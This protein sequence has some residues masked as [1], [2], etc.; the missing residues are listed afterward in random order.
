MILVFEIGSTTTLV[1]AFTDLDEEYPRFVGGGQAPTSVDEGDVTIGLRQAIANMEETTGVTGPYKLLLATSSAAGGLKMTVHGL[2]HDMTVRAA[3]E[4]ALGAGANI[5]LITSGRL[6]RTDLAK[7][8]AIEPNIILLA[9]GVDYGERETALFNAEQLLSLDLNVPVIYAG[10]VE[11]Q[12]EIRL[13]FEEAGKLERLFLVDNV[14]PRI[15]E[16][17]VLP[18]REVIQAVF[19]DH[20][21]HA[22]GM[23]KIRDMINSKIIPTPGSVMLATELIASELGDVMTVDV[24]GATTDI[25]SVTEGSEEIAKLQIAPEPKSKRTVEGDLGL[26]INRDNLLALIDRRELLERMGLTEELLEEVL[27]SYHP[28]PQ[29]QAERR[30]VHVLTEVAAVV[31]SHRHSGGLKDLFYTG[32]KK[33]IAIGKDLTKIHTIIGTGGALT[34]LPDTKRILQAIPDSNKGNK[35]LPPKSVQVLIDQDYIM[36]SL[37]VLSLE[38]PQ[39]ALKLLKQSLGLTGGDD[40]SPNRG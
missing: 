28:I 29:S 3:K 33:S 19:E 7:V 16:L 32:G 1:N 24:G 40:V 38:H 27:S 2:V 23:E 8:T 13:M 11:N 21:I 35:L 6:R 18:T 39:G 22:H 31:S 5:K 20:I 17:N 10:N 14:Y 4:A 25:H 15:D 34:R 37:G 30:L 9:G 12:E 36:A 26:F